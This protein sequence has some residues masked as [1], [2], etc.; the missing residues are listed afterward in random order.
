[1]DKTID[2]MNVV[3]QNQSRAGPTQAKTS[4]FRHEQVVIDEIR[5]HIQ[6]EG[7]GKL[8][9][10]VTI[11]DEATGSYFECDI[12]LVATSGIYIVELKHWSGHTTVAPY[13]WIRNHTNHIPSPHKTNHYKCQVLKG[14]YQ[15]RFRT[16]PN[17][18]VESI[19]ILTH[20]E[21][22]VEG[23]STPNVAEEWG[24]HNHTFASIL[25]FITY[26][27]KKR[28]L[29]NGDILADRQIDA[30]IRYLRG[31]DRPRRGIEYT[32][33]GYETV[34]YLYQTPESIELIAKEKDG[35]IRG[36]SRFRVFRPPIEA[37]QEEKQRFVKKATNALKAVSDIGYH[38]NILKVVQVPNDYG[39]IIEMSAWSETGT[40]RDLMH[41][42]D[43]DFDQ[44]GGLDICRG[45]AL[46]L[47]AAHEVSVIHR[48]VKPENILMMNDIPK[49]MNF[50]LSYQIE[51]DRLTVMPDVS[52]I[53]DDGYVAPEILMGEDIDEGTDFF[54]FGVIAYEM[55]VG[56]KPCGTTREFCAQGGA[57]SEQAVSKLVAKGVPSRTIE[58]IKGMLLADRRRRLKNAEQIICAFSKDT[59]AGQ[60]SLTPVAHN[61][62]LQPGDEHDAYTIIELIGKGGASQVYK[63]ETWR[64]RI[65]ALKVFNK[66]I[67][68]ERIF[69]EYDITSAIKS[70]YVVSCDQKVGYWKK[71][72]YFMAME[73]IEGQ[74]MRE[75]INEGQRPDID[76]FR[77]VS[78]CL[79]EAVKAFHE[80]EDADGNPDPLLHSD[81]KPENILITDDKK[82]VLIDCGTAGRP[83]VDTF[84]G[85]DGYVPPDN[86]LKTDMQFSQSGDLFAL[87]VTLWEWLF[88]RQPYDSPSIGDVSEI[89]EDVNEDIRKY[90]PW[91]QKAVS[92]E[93][94]LRFNTIEDMHDAFLSCDRDEADTVI[95]DGEEK[96]DIVTRPIEDIGEYEFI[97]VD[98]VKKPV[99]EKPLKTVNNP[100]V[101]Y[102]NSLSSVSA[103]NENATAESQLEND[104]FERIY[105]D[106]PIAKH[107]YSALVDQ[108]IN[109]ILTGNAGDG[110]T[111]IAAEV[112]GRVKGISPQSL[113]RREDI[114]EAG[115]VV[116]KDM[117][118]LAEE[119]RVKTL[120]EAIDNTKGRY[121][122]VSNTGTLL[123]SFRRLE[124][125]GLEVDESQILRALESDK[126]EFVLNNSFQIINIGRT[127]SIDTACKVFER[128][129]EPDG[130]HLCTEC[131]LGD[132]C[133][134]N[135]NVM[136]LQDGLDIVHTRVELIYRRLYEYGVRLTMRQMTGHLAYAIT[137]GLNCADIADMSHT[138]LRAR[139]LGST[140]F[141]RF[142]GDDGNEIVPEATQL[143]SIQRIRAAG[144]GVFLDPTFER[145]AWTHSDLPFP[146]T[147]LAHDLYHR[148]RD[149]S[150]TPPHLVRRQ[151]RRLVYFF[152]LLDDKNGREYI[153]KFL[154]S[155]TL[156][157]FLKYLRGAHGL[158]QS[159][160]Q[161]YRSHI[162]QVLQEHFIRVR[163]PETKQVMRDLYITLGHRGNGA[164][165]Q[166]ILATLREDDFQVVLKPR[167]RLGQKISN[168]FCLSYRDDD[169]VMLLDLP[170]LDYVA[171]RYKG[172]IA[173]ELSAN[174]TNRLDR[175][176]IE[177]LNAYNRDPGIR[178]NGDNS[179]ALL[180][181]GHEYEF[182]TMAIQP[183]DDVLGVM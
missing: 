170:F 104:L 49:L 166:M 139:Y 147:G 59:K 35:R 119:N 29:P 25:D 130:W 70:S 48:A 19:V 68:R 178:R 181:I 66:E 135:R 110:K 162:L 120:K 94:I 127:D 1:M 30:I 106:N 8:V 117:S 151:I 55:L 138:N 84:G 71:D 126:P 83:R 11:H 61:E 33:Q 183:I 96:E 76:T 14:M 58:A 36:L 27:R 51:D 142:F 23:A 46:S 63:A 171:R 177:L 111:T 54:S 176:K 99:V 114:P 42:H 118:E 143:L 91:L 10:N 97:H 4:L 72:R 38:P 145:E 26:I 116:I 124:A 20:P 88:G 112:V 167:Y 52:A 164:A 113:S 81:V 157:D 163:L 74:S 132:Y 89:P 12:I 93:E 69:N 141:N 13:Q 90:L 80:H 137:A 150:N 85:S 28:N 2:E 73:Y 40:L 168:I 158:Q 65:V 152:G 134:I 154:Q 136:L 87:G 45:I 50:D 17:L 172:E 173:E 53:K 21:S 144:F 62:Q 18:W 129:L 64:G 9:S 182:Q 57:L 107:V 155:P 131:C 103:A 159:L 161:Q 77:T 7:I 56:N 32:I 174:Y 67:P 15:H 31:L 146:L 149:A 79:M 34:E 160:E 123:E 75:I 3:E 179:L 102:L 39:D 180:H 122:I 100:F 78:L 109:V 22:D 95:V 148:L 128:M 133:P 156:L 16:Y 121:L 41:E 115:L 6:S 44:A 98:E 175:F 140:F 125:D 43:D 60:R 47:H 82:A 105:V 92:T 165:T 24:K 108:N 37:T 5:H 153:C 169:A 86:I 101:E